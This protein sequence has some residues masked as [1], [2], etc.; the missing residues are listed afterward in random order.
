MFFSKY[1][2]WDGVVL[3]MNMQDMFLDVEVLGMIAENLFYNQ[4][5]NLRDCKYQ[6]NQD[7]LEQNFFRAC[8]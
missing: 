6:E 3:S 4:D 7:G 1:E 8:T 2:H 5:I